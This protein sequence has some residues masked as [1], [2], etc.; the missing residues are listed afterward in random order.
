MGF[1]EAGKRCGDDSKCGICISKLRMH[2][3]TT[4]EIKSANTTRQSPKESKP[5]ISERSNIHLQ[6]YQVPPAPPQYMQA[7]LV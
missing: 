1:N 5:N 3:L 6:L 7:V 2:F 4:L